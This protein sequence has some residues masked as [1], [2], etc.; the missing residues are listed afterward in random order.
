MGKEGGG[1]TL[2]HF[3]QESYLVFLVITPMFMVLRVCIEVTLL[4]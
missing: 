1:V 3:I 2:T 4:T